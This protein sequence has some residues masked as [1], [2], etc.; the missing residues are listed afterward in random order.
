M[1]IINSFLEWIKEVPNEFS[2]GSNQNQTNSNVT[3]SPTL[4]HSNGTTTP[5]K[6]EHHHD[7]ETFVPSIPSKNPLLSV[8]LSSSPA[9]NERQIDDSPSQFEEM[10][11][12][13]TVI[14]YFLLFSFHFFF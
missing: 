12:R 9:S 4:P 2:Q 5:S 11:N 8:S 7:S 10:K 6:S 1:A 13:K 3:S 14:S